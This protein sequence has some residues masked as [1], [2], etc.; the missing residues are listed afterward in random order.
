MG[1]IIRETGSNSRSCARIRLLV[2]FPNRKRVGVRRM[3]TVHFV[4]FVGFRR[5]G[6]RLACLERKRDLYNLIFYGLITLCICYKNYAK[7][8]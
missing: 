5:F 1:L 3:T 2:Y 7:L 6:F 8:L 4:N